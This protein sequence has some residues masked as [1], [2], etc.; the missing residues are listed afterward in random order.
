MESSDRK[1]P[2]FRCSDG[3][4]ST[5][6]SLPQDELSVKEWMQKNGVPDRVND[7]IFIA[8]AKALDFIDP[9]KLSMTVVLTAINRFVN[10]TSGS[11]MAFLDGNQPDRLCAPLK[12]HIEAR[13]GEV[14]TNSRVQK[15]VLNEDTTVRHLQMIGGEDI[16]ADVYVSAMPVDPVKLLLPDEWKSIPHFQQLDNLEG[17]PVINLQLWFDRK[18]TAEN[19]LMF[20]RS[21]LLSVYA[22]MSRTCREYYDPNRSI[23]HIEGFMLGRHLGHPSARCY[24]SFGFFSKESVKKKDSKARIF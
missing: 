17:I 6:S 15:I 5:H 11:R 7:E 4:V 19:N 21:P 18:L 13:G 14:R 20:S 16:E 1:K 22:D 2:G 8:M 10:E 12:G 9:D 24:A 3:A 23:S